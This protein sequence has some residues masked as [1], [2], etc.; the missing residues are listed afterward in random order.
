MNWRQSRSASATASLP[1]LERSVEGMGKSVA[2]EQ[3]RCGMRWMARGAAPRRL[4]RPC[5][6]QPDVVGS[7]KSEFTATDR[8]ASEAKGK[9]VRVRGCAR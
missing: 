1:T 5:I 8:D 9:T 7:T 3:Q 6:P 4:R 2:G